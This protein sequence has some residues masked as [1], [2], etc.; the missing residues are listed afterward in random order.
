MDSK[1]PYYAIQDVEGW[2]IYRFGIIGTSCR[3]KTFD[4]KDGWTAEKVEAVVDVLNHCH[5]TFRL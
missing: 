4:M 3:V 2:T 1:S 5:V